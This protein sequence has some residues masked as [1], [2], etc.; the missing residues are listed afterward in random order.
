MKLKEFLPEPSTALQLLVLA[1]GLQWFLIDQTNN[2][3]STLPAKSPN[4]ETHLSEVDAM[5][6]VNNSAPD[7]SQQIN[8][9]AL[10]NDDLETELKSQIDN[11]QFKQARTQLLEIAAQAAADDDEKKVG[12]IL[13]LLGGVAID[14]QE[15]NTAELLLHEA[16]EMAI[17][18]GDTMAM[19]RSYQQLGR[20]NIKT[21]ALARYASEA[22]DSLWI[23]RSQIFAGEYRNVEVDLQKI[24]DA[25]LDI[26]RYGA[27]ANALETKSEYHH[28]FHDDY[29]AQ[30]SAI[31][32][33]KLYASS[34]QVD[35]S[36]RMV[37]NLSTYGATTELIQSVSAE[38]NSLFIEHQSDAAKMAEAKD[39]Q[40]LYHHHKNSGDRAA[41]WDLRIKASKTLANTSDRSMFQR[42][43]AVMAILYSSNFAMERAK[44]YLNQASRL[45]SDQGADEYAEEAF[46]MQSLIY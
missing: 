14:E 43:A 15:I 34:G 8:R 33:A 30:E 5:R 17:R 21:R 29:R 19:G 13:L 42:Q 31:E 45:F 24:I 38:I 44:Q 25:N 26:R 12:Y 3:S 18:R 20:L 27:A 4:I 41:A 36:K 32:A 37:A 2:A 40:M 28:R 6:Q 9:L 46:G 11:G 39:L 10:N 22:Y 16:L 23:V 1:F 35:R 7:I